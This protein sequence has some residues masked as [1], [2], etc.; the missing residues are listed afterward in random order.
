MTLDDVTQRFNERIGEAPNIGK[1]LK[2][3]FDEGTVFVDLSTDPPSVS[4]EE[5]DADCTITTKIK[6]LEKIVKGETNP[7]TAMMMG[8]IKI[9]GDMSVAM[10][11]KDL[12]S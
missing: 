9:K 8:K 5:K 2:F 3:V 1:T 7:M 10:K 12:L 11:L 4:N 6:T